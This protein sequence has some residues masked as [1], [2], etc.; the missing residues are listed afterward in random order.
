MGVKVY[1]AEEIAQGARS[2]RWA[3]FNE[4]NG[5]TFDPNGGN[6]YGT[7]TP[8]SG[9]SADA[10]PVS[11]RRVLPSGR[12]VTARLGF[13]TIQHPD[14]WQVV[15]PQKQGQFITI[16]PAAGITDNGVGYGVLLNRVP[17]TR[18]GRTNIDQITAQIVEQMQEVNG[19]EPLGNAQPITVAGVV[20]RSVMLQSRSPFPAAD[21][22]PQTERDWLI[23]V[24]RPDGS[25]LFMIF[26]APQSD[27]ARFQP[28][29]EAM[30]NSLRIK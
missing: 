6:P 25:S 20:G 14:N 16:A 28:T 21:G 11:L 3:E 7:R 24:P 26:V 2:G 17:R 4:Q 8:S 18:N 29:Y 10:A 27:F 22:R 23:T 9:S 13:L 12:M 1:T 19:L 30:L 5:A 15:L